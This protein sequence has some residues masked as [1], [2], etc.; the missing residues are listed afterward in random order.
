MRTPR[1]VAESC[2]LP[3]DASGFLRRACPA[4]GRHFKLRAEGDT[5]LQVVIAEAVTHANA[6]ELP[7][8]T[9][10][11]CP[12]C[13]HTAR[14][15]LFL[16]DLQRSWVEG[17]VKL[18]DASLQRERLRIVEGHVALN[19]ASF[20]LEAPDRFPEPDDLVDAPLF[21]CGERLRLRS[22]WSDGWFCPRCRVWH[23]PD[24]TLS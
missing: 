20:D 12:Y 22:T 13:G 21:C 17:W 9:A 14:A 7:R 23:G 8:E 6:E 11:H 24:R 15:R 1:P 3:F 2:V 5:V 10:L 4:C 16:T 18:V 19:P